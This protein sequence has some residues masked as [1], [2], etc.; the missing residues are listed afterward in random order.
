MKFDSLIKHSKMRKCIVARPM[1]VVGENVLSPTNI[2]VKNEFL[3]TF[4]AWK[5]V[6]VQL[7]KNR[8]NIF[9]LLQFGIFSNLAAPWPILKASHTFSNFWRFKIALENIGQTQ[10]EDHG[11]NFCCHTTNGDFMVAFCGTLCHK[12]QCYGVHSF[13]C[14]FM[15]CNELVLIL[16]KF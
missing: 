3:F 5:I 11:K 12:C 14:S 7:T 1:F 8:K 16:V 4:K 2:H 10:L 13:E 6:V 15:T 9:C